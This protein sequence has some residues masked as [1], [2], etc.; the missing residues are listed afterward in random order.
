MHATCKGGAMSDRTLG[1]VCIVAAVAVL[2]LRGGGLP[3]FPDLPDF[4]KPDPEVSCSDLQDSDRWNDL[5]ARA[6]EIFSDIDADARQFISEQY[7]SAQERFEA[8]SGDVSDPTLNQI[9]ARQILN[10]LTEDLGDFTRRPDTARGIEAL[11]EAMT[12]QL[13]SGANRQYLAELLGE[14]AEGVN[15]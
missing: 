15:H 11:D 14:I 4:P 13:S 5:D 3:D 12:A 1:L 9:S 8:P 6:C 10:Q 2:F 7:I